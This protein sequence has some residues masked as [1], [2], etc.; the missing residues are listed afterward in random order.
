MQ[1]LGVLSALTALFIGSVICD[2]PGNCTYEDVK[3]TWLFY[4]GKKVGDKT[5][6]CSQVGKFH[7]MAWHTA[8]RSVKTIF[9]S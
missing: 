8:Y 5:I 4:V 9:D 6:N 3:G 2:T 1:L 7:A